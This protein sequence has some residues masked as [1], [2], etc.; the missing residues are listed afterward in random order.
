M[1]PR[2]KYLPS[3]SLSAL[4]AH[5]AGGAPEPLHLGQETTQSWPA[6]RTW[7][8]RDDLQ[9]IRQGREDMEV[10]VEVGRKG[11]G[12]LDPDFQRINMGLGMSV[13]A[14]DRQRT[15]FGVADLGCSSIL[16]LGLFLDAFVLGK[17]P[18]AGDP[19]LLPTAYLAQSDLDD[20]G[21][22]PDVPD[23]DL[24]KAG[25]QATLYR[26]TLWI[27]PKRSFTPF[28]RDPYVGIY[29]QRKSTALREGGMHRWI[30]IPPRIQIFLT[31][32]SRRHKDLSRCPTIF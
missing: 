16:M 6:R 32:Y 9:A 11:R 25:K 27:G 7:S 22:R 23:L 28:H 18:S 31:N 21:L 20:F 13:H 15:Q 24:Y 4:R 30:T 29:S 8:L 19:N 1:L 26:R 3:I 17:I 10:E 2:A 12:Y 14:R 5:L